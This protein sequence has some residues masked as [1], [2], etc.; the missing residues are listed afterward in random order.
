M[1]SLLPQGIFT[2]GYNWHKFL[3]ASGCF[4]EMILRLYDKCK[5]NIF[6]V[7]ILIFLTFRIHRNLHC[8]VHGSCSYLS[9]MKSETKFIIF[10]CNFVICNF[11]I[12]PCGHHNYIFGP[13]SLVKKILLQL[14]FSLRFK[15]RFNFS[16]PH[17]K[18]VFSCKLKSNVFP[19][20][21]A[22]S[23]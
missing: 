12:C 1:S 13:R 4:A 14:R 15:P 7:L 17:C 11:A 18:R 16:I 8:G 3:S 21:L 22:P 20:I 5:C 9:M 6:R 19:V 23:K 10:I 2:P